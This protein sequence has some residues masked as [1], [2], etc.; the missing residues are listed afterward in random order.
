M[1]RLGIKGVPDDLYICIHVK[2]T[3]ISKTL[4][5][6]QYLMYRLFN[7]INVKM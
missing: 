7:M 4:I 6:N 3:P 5:Y 1:S 2:E